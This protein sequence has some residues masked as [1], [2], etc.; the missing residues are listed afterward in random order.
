MKIAKKLITLLG[1][2]LLTS[3]TSGCQKNKTYN[4]KFVDDIDIC[5]LGEEYDFEPFFEK[6][7][8]F[9]YSMYAYYDDYG[10]D[11]PVEKTGDFTFIQDVYSDVFVEI[12]GKKNNLEIKG[13]KVVTVASSPDDIDNWMYNCHPMEEGIIE[14]TLNYDK[15]YIRGNDSRS[16]LKISFDDFV[17]KFNKNKRQFAI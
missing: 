11:V 9:S 7:Q 16:S 10:N 12:T 3:F 4:I 6:E 5:L 15:T 2:T 14:K 8:G 17:H 1:L 13:T